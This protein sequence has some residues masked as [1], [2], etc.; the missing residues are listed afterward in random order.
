MFDA[1]NLLAENYI[2]EMNRVFSDGFQIVTSY[3]NSKN[4]GDNW[5]SAGYA[6]WFLRESKYLNQAR[7]TLGT[8]CASCIRYTF[9]L[10]SSKFSSSRRCSSSVTR[11]TGWPAVNISS[12]AL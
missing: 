5:I 2:T 9:P 6:L 7:M 8:S 1:D 12:I 4:Y 11:S 10:P 3:R